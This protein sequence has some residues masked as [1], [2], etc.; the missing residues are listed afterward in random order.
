ME[1][2][3]DGDNIPAGRPS[4]G[5]CSE[6]VAARWPGPATPWHNSPR[7]GTPGLRS[8]HRNGAAQGTVLQTYAPPDMQPARAGTA[9][10]ARVTL[11]DISLAPPAPAQ[12]AA[13]AP[14]L[15]LRC[16]YCR[17]WMS[18]MF[19]RLTCSKC[20][21]CM[22]GPPPRGPLDC[23]SSRVSLLVWTWALNVGPL[24]SSGLVGL[25]RWQSVVQGTRLYRD[26]FGENMLSSA[27]DNNKQ[28]AQS[29]QLE[30]PKLEGPL[31]WM[32]RDM[33]GTHVVH[34]TLTEP[35]AAFSLS[36]HACFDSLQ[37][38]VHAVTRLR[39]DTAL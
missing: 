26:P 10:P 18:R 32:S 8:P 17:S 20:E 34:A 6:S 2:S 13:E 22:V 4:H 36:T 5:S 14:R 11:G 33:D 1:K 23:R 25:T 29:I 16:P 3:P 27:F 39:G 19:S 30:L 38:C 31:W 35:S 28:L 9:E 37:Q 15:R 21:H 7:A 12:V 24:C